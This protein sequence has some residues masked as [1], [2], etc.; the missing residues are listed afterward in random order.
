MLASARYVLESRRRIFREVK[1]DTK[2]AVCSDFRGPMA[3]KGVDFQQ[4]RVK[5]FR[6]SVA[7]YGIRL[8]WIRKGTIKGW[9]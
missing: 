8:D 5:A 7:L 2:V 3:H 9:V 6:V 4:D 1:L